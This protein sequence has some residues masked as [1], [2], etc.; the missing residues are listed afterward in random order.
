MRPSDEHIRDGRKGHHY[1]K[2][3]LTKE[4]WSCAPS[5]NSTFTT[6]EQTSKTFWKRKPIYIIGTPQEDGEE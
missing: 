3:T 1:M 4:P 5:T 6:Q 2:V